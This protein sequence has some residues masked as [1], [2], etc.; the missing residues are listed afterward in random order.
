MPL[1]F[2]HRKSRAVSRIVTVEP[3]APLRPISA[4]TLGAR[5][6]TD[7]TE[8]SAGM[9][10]LIALPFRVL[11]ISPEREL[12]I[13][14]SGCN[15]V[16]S[17]QGSALRAFT[18]LRRETDIDGSFKAEDVAILRRMGLVVDEDEIMKRIRER[19]GGHFAPPSLR[20][21]GIPT[22]D[23]PKVLGKCVASWLENARDHGRRLEIVVFD[24]SPSRKARE[25]NLR[26]LKLFGGMADIRYSGPEQR[27]AFWRHLGTKGVAENGGDV[28]NW[29]FAADSN[30]G[31][32]RNALM[33]DQAG[34]AFISAD[35]DT[36]ARPMIHP[37]LK[38]GIRLVGGEHC[39]DRWFFQSR[40]TALNWARWAPRDIVGD[41]A[42]ILGRSLTSALS[43]G[44]EPVYLEQ[45]CG[46]F[47]ALE[48]PL[49]I[50]GTMPGKLGDSGRG[51]PDWDV[52]AG[53]WCSGRESLGRLEF[54]ELPESTAISHHISFMA[55]TVALDLR[56][57]LPP[58]FPQHRGEDRMFAAIINRVLPNAFW[59]I[60]PHGIIH[61]RPPRG[62]ELSSPFLRWCEMIWAQ[63][64]GLPGRRQGRS[65]AEAI[66]EAGD[67][68]RRAVDSGFQ[69]LRFSTLERLGIYVSE[70][71]AQ[72]RNLSDSGAPDGKRDMLNRAHDRMLREFSALCD[73]AESAT[74]NITWEEFGRQLAAYGQLL[75]D[76]PALYQAAGEMRQQGIR[77]SVSLGEALRVF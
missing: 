19:S 77:M 66:R 35:D 45:M 41:H 25:Q 68:I 33:L 36:I 53:N 56:E 75:Q 37:S 74:A 15:I 10:N 31:T 6:A 27:G 18:R 51:D 52:W 40:S 59:G 11:S 13:S 3:E 42:S 21:V 76:W 71:L 7:G 32:V 49:R 16:T 14:P 67:D 5:G 73:R 12:I 22:R 62:T 30:F 50:I 43:S 54:A 23:R 47:A 63:L 2:R 57:I 58:F 64:I 46:H 38:G 20:S 70:R 65:D 29:S 26:Q 34:E 48:G 44:A 17:A 8:K 55:T 39:F 60:V 4:G 9:K 72:F 28:P 61:D 1:R 69:N 24:T